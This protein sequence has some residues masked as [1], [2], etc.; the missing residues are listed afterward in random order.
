[1]KTSGAKAATHKHKRAK[2]GQARRLNGW[3]VAWY[4]LLT[5]AGAALFKIGADYS[6]QECGY[7]AVG[8]EAFALLLPALYCLTSKVI[9][10]YVLDIMDRR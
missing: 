5:L 7:Y 3:T 1:M 8:G 4:V 6:M 10:D 2:S 9:C